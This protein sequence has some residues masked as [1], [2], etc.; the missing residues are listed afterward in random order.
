MGVS[1]ADV[2]GHLLLGFPR[3][4]FAQQFCMLSSESTMTTACRLDLRLREELGRS[5]SLHSLYLYSCLHKGRSPWPALSDHTENLGRG[6]GWW[7]RVMVQVG[8]SICYVSWIP[9]AHVKQ[10]RWWPASV[11]PAPVVR[12]E[13]EKGQSLCSSQL[14][15]SRSL[16]TRGK[17]QENPASTRWV[18][19]A[20]SS[21]L[22]FSICIHPMEHGSEHTDRLG[23][24][25]VV[26]LAQCV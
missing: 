6:G 8:K 18:E 22:P 15:W 3:G 5:H 4:R 14:A 26:E 16:C 17:K 13:T 2:R 24:D 7:T 10:W 9:G 12:Q 19:R 20:T 21:K 25:S 23:C 11:G 1:R